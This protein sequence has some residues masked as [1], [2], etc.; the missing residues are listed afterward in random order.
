[1]EWLCAYVLTFW[2]YCVKYYKFVSSHMQFMYLYVH[3]IY[4][5]IHYRLKLLHVTRWWFSVLIHKSRKDFYSFFFRNVM[6][7]DRSVNM[8]G[9]TVN[10]NNSAMIFVLSILFAR[11][12]AFL[13]VFLSQN[14]DII[15]IV[16]E[17][18]LHWILLFDSVCLFVCLFK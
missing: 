14:T 18:Q 12:F 11:I 6:I 4:Y 1:M 17:W 3:I 15:R 7:A 5:I 9:R 2:F 10:N 8:F 16:S 13:L